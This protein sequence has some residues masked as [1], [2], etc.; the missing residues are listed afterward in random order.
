M[1]LSL[2][3][4][5]VPEGVDVSITPE[6]ISMARDIGI[7]TP[8][9]VVSSDFTPA[10]VS[11]PKAP[12]WASRASGKSPQDTHDTKYLAEVNDAYFLAFVAMIEGDNMTD[13]VE[14]QQLDLD[15]MTNHPLHP[16]PGEI[17]YASFTTEVRVTA[18]K[19]GYYVGSLGGP[20]MNV[21]IKTP[22]SQPLEPH[23]LYLMNVTSTPTESFPFCATKVFHKLRTEDMLV[24]SIFTQIPTVEDIHFQDDTS[25]RVYQL[26]T[27]AYLIGAMIGRQGKNITALI[28]AVNNWD[29][30]TSFG[31]PEITITPTY[32]SKG[33]FVSFHEPSGCQWNLEDIEWL[34]S[35]FHC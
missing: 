34:I 33:C 4:K 2:V 8:R 5:N 24:S 20:G 28:S 3:F 21:Y 19:H 18:I 14:Q 26:P 1:A 13:L 9:D 25:T 17:S 31:E 11:A 35:H 30:S 16:L 6:D 23:S 15:G 29:S 10:I 32:D 22:P 27:P 12:S 7:L